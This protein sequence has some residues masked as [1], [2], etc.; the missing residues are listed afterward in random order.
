MNPFSPF[1]PD[2]HGTVALSRLTLLGLSRPMPP[3]ATVRRKVAVTATP[4][5]TAAGEDVALWRR[6]LAAMEAAHRSGPWE[7]A[8]HAFCAAVGAGAVGYGGYAVW[9]CMS[10]DG[11]DRAVRL[12][13]P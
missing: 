9:A 12:F 1:Q 5:T 7:R 10:G 11:F 6:S 13:L 8:L 3:A 2:D 4:S